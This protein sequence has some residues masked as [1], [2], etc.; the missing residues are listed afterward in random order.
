MDYIKAQLGEAAGKLDVKEYFMREFWKK[1]GD[2]DSNRRIISMSFPMS[3]Y[4]VR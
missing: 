2:N 4:A 1:V 3:P